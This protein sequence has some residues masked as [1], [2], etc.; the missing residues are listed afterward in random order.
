M[1]TF[2]SAHYRCGVPLCILVSAEVVCLHA[3]DS[4]PLLSCDCRPR[5]C[6]GVCM[7]TV[8]PV[9]SPFQFMLPRVGPT[10][11][12]NPHSPPN[13]T[14]GT[15]RGARQTGLTHHLGG[16]KC[17]WK[18]SKQW[19]LAFFSSHTSGYPSPSS[20]SCQAM[21]VLWRSEIEWAP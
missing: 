6:L 15:A 2:A 1:S 14:V 3:L 8:C 17:V 11:A 20:A 12:L 10:S 5:G 16:R 21:N 9:V 7:D 18:Y 19:A 13:H 4:L